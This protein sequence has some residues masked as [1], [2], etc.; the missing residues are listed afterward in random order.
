[1]ITSYNSLT[2]GKYEALLRA[3]AD[4]E[5][6]T[7]ELNLHVLSILSDMTVDQLLDLKV[8]EFRAMMDR[9]G[10]LCTA[11]RPSEVAKQYRFGDLVL[12]PVTDVRKM[13]AAQYIDFQNF[14]NAGEGRQ[15]ELLSCFLV[16]KGMKYNDGYDILEVQQA[17][18]DFMP[19][20]AALGLLAFFFEKIASFNN[21]YP[22]LFGKEDAEEPAD[23]EGDPG[24]E[25]VDPF[26]AKWGWIANVDAVSE[27]TRTPWAEV[28]EMPVIEFL[29]ML[30]YR[31]DKIEQKKKEHQEWIRTH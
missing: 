19:V 13:T 14:S 16:P 22:T 23:G 8:P 12:V 27:L 5:G 30:A 7:N 21:Q 28:W 29:N 15:A 4:H 26:T 25:P 10:F 31:R 18:R 3:R 1:M 6:D 17:I 24:D 11:P 2:V 20:T 9:A